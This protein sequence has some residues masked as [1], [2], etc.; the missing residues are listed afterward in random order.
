MNKIVVSWRF[1]TP[2]IIMW[3]VAIFFGVIACSYVYDSAKQLSMLGSFFLG[4]FVLSVCFLSR[5]PKETE[6]DI[7]NGLV[8]K[9]YRFIFGI[10]KT[11]W[12]SLK[13]FHSVRSYFTAGRHTVNVVELV[14]KGE[15]ESVRVAEFS[16]DSLAGVGNSDSTKFSES[17]D[18]IRLRKKIAKDC[19]L[20]NAGF[21]GFE[22][23]ALKEMKEEKK[24]LS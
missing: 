4:F 20:V 8:I 24:N 16:P 21:A 10:S 12:Y 11:K 18:A 2:V 23:F 19:S 22:W 7:Q 14:A 6:I 13:S 9:R 1:P 15:K 5:R 17:E 3:C